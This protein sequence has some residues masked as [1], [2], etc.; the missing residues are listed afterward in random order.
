MRNVVKPKLTFVYEEAPENEKLVQAMYG[1]LLAIAKRNILTGNLVK[2]K[3]QATISAK[4]R[5]VNDRY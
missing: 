5:I 1:N 3:M 2:M 4:A